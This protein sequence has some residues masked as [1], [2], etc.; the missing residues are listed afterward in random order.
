MVRCR[1]LRATTGVGRAAP[2]ALRHAGGPRGGAAPAKLRSRDL[3]LTARAAALTGL[4]QAPEAPGRLRARL[5]QAQDLA[6]PDGD[7]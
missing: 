7:Q 1:P 6:G 2:P 5:R 4:P 3:K